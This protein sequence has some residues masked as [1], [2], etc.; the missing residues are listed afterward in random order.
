MVRLSELYDCKEALEDLDE[1]SKNKKD[2]NWSTVMYS[3]HNLLKYV[4]ILIS[5]TLK[6]YFECTGFSNF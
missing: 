4:S 1:L 6:L 5:L 3:V 2:T